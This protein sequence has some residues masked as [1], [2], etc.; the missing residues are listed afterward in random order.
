MDYKYI[1]QLLE[2]YWQCET[3]LQEE[4]ILRTFFSQDDVPAC[5]Q[6]YKALFTLQQEKETLDDDFDTRILEKVGIEQ[7]K[8]KIITFTSRLMPLF[9]AAAVVAI[10]LTLGNAA[11]AP[12]DRGWD[13]PKEAYA[14]FHQQQVTDSVNSLGT[15]QAENITDT[16]KVGNTE[17]TTLVE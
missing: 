1:E 11:Q 3:T 7:P 13:D 12:W 2:R 5:L 14:K 9:R 8:A 15:I 10:I 6:Q 17:R 4:S 16:I